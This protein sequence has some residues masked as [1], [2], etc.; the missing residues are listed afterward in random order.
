GIR[1]DLVTGVQTCALP[2]FA[3][4]EAMHESLAGVEAGA[5]QP[6][7]FARDARSVV[8]QDRGLYAAQRPS[9]ALFRRRVTE[10]DENLTAALRDSIGANRVVA[11]QRLATRKI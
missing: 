8:V 4:P 5:F 2:I 11:N 7:H 6:G 3:Q 1:D 9:A 10:V